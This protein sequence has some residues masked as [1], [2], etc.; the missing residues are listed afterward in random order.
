IHIFNNM[1]TPAVPSTPV[2]KKGGNPVIKARADGRVPLSP[3]PKVNRIPTTPPR[4]SSKG[5]KSIYGG[6]LS[7]HFA[8]LQLSPR[9]KAKKAEKEAAASSSRRAAS[10]SS[11]DSSSRSK[12]TED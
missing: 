5:D 7:Q 2:K 10:S 9:S 1:A 8:K 12:S 6:N 11:L 3:S 4:K